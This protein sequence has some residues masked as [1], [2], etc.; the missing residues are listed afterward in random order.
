M[1]PTR[2]ELEVEIRE[3]QYDLEAFQKAR[4]LVRIRIYVSMETQRM[5]TPLHTW[6]GSDAVVGS[7]DLVIHAI[8]RTISE[9]EEMLNKSEPTE[10]HPRLIGPPLKLV[11]RNDDEHEG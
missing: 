7:L 4:D 11:K 6:S 5:L 10:T 2:Q 8:E 9:L 3:Q 1:T